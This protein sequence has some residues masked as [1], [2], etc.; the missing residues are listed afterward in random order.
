MTPV[1]CDAGPTHIYAKHIAEDT[2]SRRL[3][4]WT[5]NPLGPVGVK[6]SLL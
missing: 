5:R 2:V 3:S 1:G 6:L 4:S